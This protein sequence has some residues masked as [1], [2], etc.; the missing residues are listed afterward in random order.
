LIKVRDDDYEMRRCFYGYDGYPH[1]YDKIEDQEF[2]FEVED[3]DHNH[4]CTS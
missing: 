2:D 1:Y 4:N 3:S